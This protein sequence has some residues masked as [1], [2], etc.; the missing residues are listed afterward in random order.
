MRPQPEIFLT[1]YTDI[2][3]DLKSLKSLTVSSKIL[4]EC[5]YLLVDLTLYFTIG[6]R[7]GIR[8]PVGVLTGPYLIAIDR[9]MTIVEAVR[10]QNKG[11][12]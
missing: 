5:F 7:N 6:R 9:T 11:R 10:M 2:E 8:T 4:K 1:K 3:A 12:P